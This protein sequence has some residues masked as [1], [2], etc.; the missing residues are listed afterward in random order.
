MAK[1]R[2]DKSRKMKIS[3][4]ELL[5]PEQKDTL[6]RT[7]MAIVVLTLVIG[8]GLYLWY[9]SKQLPKAVSEDDF[10]NAVIACIPLRYDLA[11][12]WGSLRLETRYCN[13]IDVRVIDY[14]DYAALKGMAMR[15]RPSIEELKSLPLSELPLHLDL[16]E[17]ELKR[18]EVY[19]G[20]VT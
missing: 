3:M 13:T 14:G 11:Q 6:L 18:S 16:C 10:K 12:S 8:S 19:I 4:R 17:G 5:I 1:K 7:L 9:D 2:E 20:I 15:C